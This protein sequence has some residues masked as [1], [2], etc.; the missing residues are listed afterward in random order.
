MKQKD[1][2]TDLKGQRTKGSFHCGYSN[3]GKGKQR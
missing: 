3:G 1:V 2:M